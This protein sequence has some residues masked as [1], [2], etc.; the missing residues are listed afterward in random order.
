MLAW[1]QPPTP[2]PS[3]PYYIFTDSEATEAVT[4]VGQL[5]E[6]VSFSH[7]L[8]GQTLWQH[9]AQDPNPL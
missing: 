2:S 3:A 1:K 9:I 8:W 5:D 7:F 6:K 4:V